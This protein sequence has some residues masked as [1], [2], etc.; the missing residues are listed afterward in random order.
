MVNYPREDL[1]NVFFALSEHNRRDILQLISEGNS[2]L[3]AISLHIPTKTS[4]VNVHKHLKILERAELVRSI[5]KGREVEYTVNPDPFILALN[6]LKAFE[7]Y[8]NKQFDSLEKYL[9]VSGGG[10]KKND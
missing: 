9:G 6:R 5:K 3:S 4:Q 8:W 7:A 10:D 2:T 1:D